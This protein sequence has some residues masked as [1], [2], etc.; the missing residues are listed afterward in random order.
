MP[1]SIDP[2]PG[3]NEIECASCGAYFYYELT[4]C[5]ACGV[6]V[7]E[8]E[9]DLDGEYGVNASDG[10][11]LRFRNFLRKVFGKP[12]SAE[13]VFGDSLDQAVLYN[14]LLRKVG[15]DPT[16]VE[17]LVA[18]EQEQIPDGTRSIWL[19]NAIHRWEKDNRTQ[20]GS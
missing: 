11:I 14:D 6:N 7:Y 13:E 3:E 17:R 4:R 15:G 10:L 19:R 20:G 1:T 8:P 9:E 12:Y 5:P 2:Q 16:V 18:F